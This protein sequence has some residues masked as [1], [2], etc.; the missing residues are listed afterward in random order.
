MYT[1]TIINVSSIIINID[2]NRFVYRLKSFLKRFIVY[3]NLIILQ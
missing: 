2:A 3:S 1:N